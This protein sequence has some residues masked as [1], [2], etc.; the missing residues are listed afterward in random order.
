MH[1]TTFLSFYHHKGL[2]FPIRFT[3]TNKLLTLTQK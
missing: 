1:Y 2:K 3:Y